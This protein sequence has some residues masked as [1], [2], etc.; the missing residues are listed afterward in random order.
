MGRRGSGTIC[1]QCS[2]VFIWR[3]VNGNGCMQFDDSKS[4]DHLET[5]PDQPPAV[6]ANIPERQG[7]TGHNE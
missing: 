6:V 1:E 4:G 3:I 7:A 2:F 5:M